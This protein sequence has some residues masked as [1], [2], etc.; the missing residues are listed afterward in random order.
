[1]EE[2][3][4]YCWKHRML[5]EQLNEAATDAPI[6]IVDPGLHNHNSGPD[7]F[8]AKVKINGNVWVGNVEIHQRSTDWYR[9][10]HHT[11]PAYDNVIL[12]VVAKVDGEVETSN[13][14]KLPQVV[15]EVPR[16]VQE[17]YRQLLAIDRYPP[18]YAIIPDL[19]RIM[20][21]SWMNAL[22][23]ERL[24]Q[25]TEAIERRVKLC[26]GSWEA[27]YFATLARSFGF[28]VNT[29]AFEM[30]ALTIPPHTA[31][32]HRDD[33]FQ[34][35][36]L[37]FGQAGLLDA[38][39]I[40]KKR[41]QQARQDDYFDRLGEEYRYLSHKF[42][43]TPIDGKIWR[44]MRLR[45]QNFPYIRLAQLANLYCSRK[46]ELGRL[47]DC[48]TTRQAKELLQTSAT[49]Y[50][51]SHYSFG[52]ESKRAGKHL[53]DASLNILIINAVVPML[54]AYGRHLSREDLTNRALDFLQ[55]I[56]PEAN[57]VVNMWKAC[58]L[59]AENAGDSQALLQLKSVYCDKRDCLRCRIGYEYLKAKK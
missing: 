6:E 25:K 24:Q 41:L 19:S 14:Q 55:E 22:Q 43:L 7:F 18:C 5:P 46:A 17:N 52:A 20:V 47:C 42:N 1:M 9:H 23:I 8:N 57:H 58:G 10:N 2:L 59:E 54:F 12:H 3:L 37:F 13:G 56:K 31:D 39:N 48:E 28:G 26:D 44:F 35:E 27:A 34:T 29:D 36:A 53:S 4:H 16:H 49:E 32:H 11:D 38:E 15:I 51:Q 40:D 30:W 21:H 33:I 50:W 45:P